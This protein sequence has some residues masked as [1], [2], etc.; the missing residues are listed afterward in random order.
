MK[1]LIYVILVAA[2]IFLGCQDAG[3]QEDSI[4]GGEN[5]GYLSINVPEYAPWLGQ[6]ESLGSRGLP[7]SEPGNLVLDTE[8]ADSRGYLT[9]ST[10]SLILSDSSGSSVL[11]TT[12]ITGGSDT[13]TN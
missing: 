2:L 3:L 5:L 6:T 9:A 13:L 4:S 7:D 8:S 10:I 1:H 12:S 11:A